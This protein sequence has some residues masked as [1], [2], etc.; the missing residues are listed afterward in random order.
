MPLSVWRQS[1]LTE[2][3]L[4]KSRDGKKG[5][6]DRLFMSQ[7][8]I[9]ARKGRYWASPNP[10]VG[11]VLVRDGLILGTG[12][13]QPVGRDHA[14]IQA[15]KAAQYAFDGDV[16]G[17]TAYVTLEPCA[18]QGRTAPCVDALIV[19]GVTRVVAAI[20]DPNPQVAGQGFTKLRMAGIEVVVGVMAEEAETEIQGFLLRIRRGYGRVRLKLGCSLDG[21]SAMASGESQWITGPEAR[22]DVQR[23][24]AVSSVIVTGSGT[25]LTDDCSLTVRPAELGLQEDELKRASNRK[26]MRALLDS[27][28]RVPV[29]AK[30]YN[31]ETETLI[32]CSEAFASK[33]AS[34][35]IRKRAELA[36]LQRLQTIELLPVAEAGIEVEQ[37]SGQCGLD[38]KTILLKL[39]ARG[40]NEIL[41]EAGPRL[42]AAFLRE[43]LVDEL[44]IYLAPRLLGALARPMIELE[45]ARLV[46]S[47]DL[48]YREISQVGSDLRILAHCKGL[49]LR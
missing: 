15:L 17:A 27:R 42:A 26:P 7:A 45:I 38:L 30:F 19:A 25:A 46:D 36:V 1:Q 34:Q 2:A 9:E 41:I 39:G 14:E 40:A 47:I 3:D 6:T 10:H 16:F 28:L 8:L 44:V 37:F 4:L 49:R 23:L 48:D 24:R 31:G 35:S 12:F 20:E 5:D 22:R 29:N 33:Q 32:F 18:H 11:C 43:R 21:R 13:T